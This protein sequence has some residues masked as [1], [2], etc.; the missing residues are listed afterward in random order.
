MMGTGTE[1]ERERGWG[2]DTERKTGTGTRAGMETRTVYVETG[3]GREGE[4][5]R[6]LELRQEIEQ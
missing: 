1:R 5:E 6:G 3:G 4:Q 2:R